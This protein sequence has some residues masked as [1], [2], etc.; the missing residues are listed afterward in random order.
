MPLRMIYTNKHMGHTHGLSWAAVMF[1]G[2]SVFFFL[3]FF[4]T[5]PLVVFNL[6]IFCW[7]QQ[8]DSYPERAVQ[9]RGVYMWL[10]FVRNGAAWGGGKVEEREESRG[11]Q[12][13][14]S[15]S[16]LWILC[17][18]VCLLEEGCVFECVLVCRVGER[19]TGQRPGVIM[20]K[21]K[22]MGSVVWGGETVKGH[23]VFGSHRG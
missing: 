15:Q 23:N 11:L 18:N 10:L 3:F 19:E 7:L 9:G 17:M 2:S 16:S 21:G 22:E 20:L 4:L 8:M 12:L 6:H 14:C 5:Q 13:R 1:K